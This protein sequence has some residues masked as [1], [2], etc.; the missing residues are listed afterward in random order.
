LCRGG[1]S[2]DLLEDRLDL[3][4]E[5][6]ERSSQDLQVTDQAQDE[7]QEEGKCCE[8]KGQADGER[9]ERRIAAS[10]GRTA[11]RS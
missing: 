11:G 8:P 4:L 10:I 3:L 9:H 6:A 7:D 1:L 5:P 2:P